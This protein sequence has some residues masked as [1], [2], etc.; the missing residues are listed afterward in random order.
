MQLTSKYVLPCTVKQRDSLNGLRYAKFM[1]M[2]ASGK[3]SLDP[4]KLPPTESISYNL[5]NQCPIGPLQWWRLDGTVFTPVMTDLAAAPE[6]L[7]SLCMQ[8]K[9][10]L[11]SKN[12]C[13]TNLMFLSQK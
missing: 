8:C 11:S 13:G 12:L 5:E 10:K 6:S 9:C 1:E 2:V 7:L 4:Q 3:T